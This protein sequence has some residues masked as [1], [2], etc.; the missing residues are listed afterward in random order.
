MNSSWML[1]AVPRSIDVGSLPS[2]CIVSPLW[3]PSSSSRSS[4]SGCAQVLRRLYS[5]TIFGQ[6]DG[7][8]KYSE[9]QITHG[10]LWWSESCECN[11]DESHKTK[12]QVVVYKLLLCEYATETPAVLCPDL[13]CSLSLPQSCASVS[14][15]LE[16]CRRA[17]QRSQLLLKSPTDLCR[18]LRSP[19]I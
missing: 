10:I 8:Y 13:S 15:A 4:L 1:L 9:T 2:S 3:P 19:K 6:T 11:K 12:W 5:T 14:A 18:G 16:V 17:A 7:M